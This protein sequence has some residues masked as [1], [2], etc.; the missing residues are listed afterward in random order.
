LLVIFNSFR[1]PQSAHKVNPNRGIAARSRPA[2][3]VNR[4]TKSLV[5][6]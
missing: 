6:N 1:Q 5:Y 3:F 2:A 4:K